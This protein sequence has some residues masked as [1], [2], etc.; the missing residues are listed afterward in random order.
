MII[1]RDVGLH[2]YYAGQYDQA[3][4]EA[5]NTLKLDRDFGRAHTLL[6][7]AYLKKAR[8]T[9]AIA[10]FK[11]VVA[12]STSGRDRAMLAQAYALDGQLAEARRLLNDLLREARV[13]PY[14]IAVIYAGLGDQQRA[15]DYLQKA[16]REGVSSLVYLKVDPRL[17]SLRLNP[18]FRDLAKLVGLPE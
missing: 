16:Y 2:H 4:E 15:F 1:N 8:F 18:R 17:E 13:S 5:Q 7:L 14:Y 3:I 12:Q 10:E 11:G 6:G 9:E